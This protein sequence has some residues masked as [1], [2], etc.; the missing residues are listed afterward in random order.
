[1]TEEGERHGR[2]KEERTVER[3]DESIIEGI[4][5]TGRQGGATH[6][7]S[8][9]QDHEMMMMSVRNKTARELKLVVRKE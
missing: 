1:V 2:G 5:G 6:R 9:K 7:P 3:T 8:M 4:E